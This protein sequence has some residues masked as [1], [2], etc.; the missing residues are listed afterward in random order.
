M[1][2][3]ILIVF[4]LIAPMNSISHNT[5]IATYCD[6]LGQCAPGNWRIC[7]HVDPNYSSGGHWFSAC[8][9]DLAACQAAAAHSSYSSLG[10]EVSGSGNECRQVACCESGNPG[11]CWVTI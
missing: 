5:P 3:S 1:V 8:A 4:I 7:S 10:C 2:K 9:T 11:N 6:S